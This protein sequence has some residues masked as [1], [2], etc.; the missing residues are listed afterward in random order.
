MGIGSYIHEQT[1]VSIPAQSG[2]GPNLVVIDLA[3]LAFVIVLEE[4]WVEE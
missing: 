4:L 2:G 3:E 1:L